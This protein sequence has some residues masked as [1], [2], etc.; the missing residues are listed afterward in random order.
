M[1]TIDTLPS[2]GQNLPS[3]HLLDQIR[4]PKE[5]REARE[6]QT[7]KYN[8]ENMTLRHTVLILE[9]QR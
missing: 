4:N 2:S 7:N 1:Y 9:V 5:I 8:L 6:K 3:T